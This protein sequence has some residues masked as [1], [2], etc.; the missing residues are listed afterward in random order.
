MNL[1]LEKVLEERFPGVDIVTDELVGSPD[2][3]IAKEMEHGIEPDIYLY[4]GLIQMDDKV[5]ADKLYDLSREEF[6]GNFYLSAVSE[7]MGGDGALYFLPGPVY[8]YGIVYDKT[9]FAEL[10]LSVTTATRSSRPFWTR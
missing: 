1:D 6:T 3:I 5:V 4:E 9:A 8:V 7:C 10:G 2:Y